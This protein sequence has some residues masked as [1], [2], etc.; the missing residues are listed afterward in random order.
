MNIS[1]KKKDKIR[2]GII[3]KLSALYGLPESTDTT[4]SSKS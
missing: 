1:L 2:S 3:E 4:K